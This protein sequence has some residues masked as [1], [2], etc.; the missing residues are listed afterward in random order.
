M[1]QHGLQAPQRREPTPA[2]HPRRIEDSSGNILNENNDGG[3]GHNFRVSAVVEPDTYYIRV[4]G[5][6]VPAPI[7]YTLTIQMEE[8]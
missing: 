3:E 4:R 7:L 5:Y 6:D 1:R 2:G 8:E